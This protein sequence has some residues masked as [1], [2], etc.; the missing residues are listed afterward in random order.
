MP[1]IV[2]AR[3]PPMD[4]EELDVAIQ[5]VEV[6]TRRTSIESGSLVI[7]RYSALPFYR[8]L[9][10]DVRALGSTML[11]SY[12]DHQYCATVMDWYG[13]LEGLTPRTWFRLEDVP[14]NIPVVL[15]GSTN[16]RKDKWDTHMFAPTQDKRVEVYLRLMEDSFIAAQDLVIREYVPLKQYGVGIRNLPIT[17]EFRFFVLDGRVVTCGYYWSECWDDLDDKPDAA[18]VPQSLLNEVIARVPVR[19]FVVDIGQTESG[20][21][22]VIE[23]NDAQMSGLSMCNPDLLYKALS[24]LRHES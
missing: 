22:I 4:T 17:K 16:S 6:T 23:I 5:H 18:E 2:L 8:E 19:F 3:V 12:R 21:W 11:T 9:C 13:D 10:D 14:P 1:P 15:K 20:E 24:E 7:C